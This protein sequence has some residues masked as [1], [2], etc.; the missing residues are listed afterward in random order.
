VNGT[1]LVQVIKAVSGNGV[2][3]SSEGKGRI[4]ITIT[5]SYAEEEN[6]M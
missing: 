6:R 1:K 2:D 5:R 4:T 3:L